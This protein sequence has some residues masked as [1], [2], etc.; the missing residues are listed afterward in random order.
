[1]IF[2]VSLP[3]LWVLHVRPDTTYAA[4]GRSGCSYKTP[5]YPHGDGTLKTAMA[6]HDEK[7][8]KKATGFGRTPK[9][10]AAREML[11]SLGSSIN[12][13]RLVYTY[14]KDG[15]SKMSI[16]RQ[17]LRDLAVSEEI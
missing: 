17:N 13:T 6:I 3:R 12:A 2:S 4:C 7:C 11:I 16:I 9:K 15:V 5:A 8:G 1:M 10:G 14:G